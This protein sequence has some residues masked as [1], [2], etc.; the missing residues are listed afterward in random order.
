MLLKIKSFILYRQFSP[1]FCAIFINHLYFCRKYLARAIRKYA[2]QM[3][4]KLLDYG[5]GSK[6][7]KDLFAGITQYIGV[8]IDDNSGHDHKN[9]DI[10]VFYDGV[11]LPFANGEFDSVFS[12]EVLEHVPNI[13]NSLKEI[14]RV[15]KPDGQ[16]LLT[17]PFVFPEHEVPNDYR[18]LTVY[19]VEQVLKECGFEII[20]VEKLGSSFEVLVQL[21]MLYAHKYMYINRLRWVGIILQSIFLSPLCIMGVIGGFLF[22][23]HQSIYF[24]ICVFAQKAIM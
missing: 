14:Y 24:D 10:D 6:P 15:L 5:C 2:P 7:Y 11:R 21:I 13:H 8:D 17:L 16:I 22:R 19:G 20:S 18:R 4:G 12:S 3:T 23:K 9:E 1:D